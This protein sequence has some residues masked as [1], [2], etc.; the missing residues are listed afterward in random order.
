MF[1]GLR[2]DT[3]RAYNNKTHFRNTQPDAISLAEYFKINGYATYGFGKVLHNTHRDDQSWTE[4]QH[5]LVEKQYASSE[6][7]GKPLDRR[8]SR[9]KQFD[10]AL[11]GTDV[12]DDA[13]RD[14]I[15]NQA[16]IET[17]EEPPSPTSPSFCSWATINPTRP[18][19]LPRSIRSLRKECSLAAN[20]FSPQGSP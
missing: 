12:D 14:G 9:I 5:Y 16:A 19:T 7:E 17:L 20:P 15:T 3:V 13:Y 11:E 2:P 8:D 6:F 18:S 4:P 1:T 10:P